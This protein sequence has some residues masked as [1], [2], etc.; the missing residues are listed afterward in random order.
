MTEKQSWIKNMGAKL[1][2]VK[3]ALEERAENQSDERLSSLDDNPFNIKN[4]NKRFSTYRSEIIHGVM[5]KPLDKLLEREANGEG[6]DD[7]LLTGLWGFI[8]DEDQEEDPS[9]GSDEQT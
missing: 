5:L 4:R 1:S 2:S 8:D 3:N 7:G 9:G 6:N